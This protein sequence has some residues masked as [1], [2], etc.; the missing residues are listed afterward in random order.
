MDTGVVTVNEVRSGYG[1]DPVEWGDLPLML[2][3][4]GEGGGEEEMAMD[5]MKRY[6]NNI[7][8]AGL[9]TKDYDKQYKI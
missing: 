1:L 2:Q 4:Q 8:R 9:I 7:Y 5:M 6:N 3:G